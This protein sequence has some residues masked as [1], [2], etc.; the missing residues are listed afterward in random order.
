M[1]TVVAAVL[2]AVLQVVA[3]VLAAVLQMVAA[4][5]AVELQMVAAALAAVLQMV[6]AALAVEL[7]MMQVLCVRVRG[8][9][10][11]NSGLWIEEEAEPPWGCASASGRTGIKA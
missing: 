1:Q 7:Q 3:T 9:C 6:A 2:A 8:R 5:L 10:R 4:A 11:R